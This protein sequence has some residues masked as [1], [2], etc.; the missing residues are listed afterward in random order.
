[1]NTSYS[2]TATIRLRGQIT[3][4]QEVR[5]HMKW[6]DTGS[7]VH[8]DARPFEIKITPYQEKTKKKVDWNRLWDQ[9]KLVRSFEGKKGNLS[10][11]I[12]KDR[13]NH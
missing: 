12:I 1:M 2:S 9:I 7:V 10:G 11:F 4:P 6:I 5:K 13:E 3:I 8:V